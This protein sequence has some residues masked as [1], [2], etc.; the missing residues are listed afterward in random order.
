MSK[1]EQNLSLTLSCLMEKLLFLNTHRTTA[2][3]ERFFF[4]KKGMYKVSRNDYVTR[5]IQCL[6]KHSLTK[7]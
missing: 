7:L 6:Y 3:I 2:P 1:Q 4:T 5:L